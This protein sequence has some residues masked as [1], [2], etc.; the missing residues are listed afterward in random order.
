MSGAASMHRRAFVSYTPPSAAGASDSTTSV[1]GA[2]S[3]LLES[4]VG[5]VAYAAAA[6]TNDTMVKNTVFFI[7]FL[8]LG[9]MLVDKCENTVAKALIQHV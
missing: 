9:S 6:N 1:C 7:S 8:P 5:A 3:T 2:V 4:T